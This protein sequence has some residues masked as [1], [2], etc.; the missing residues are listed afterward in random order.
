[1]FNSFVQ[2]A[3]IPISFLDMTAYKTL[4]GNVNSIA[5]SD[6][7]QM[8]SNVKPTALVY[9]DNHRTQAPGIKNL[10]KIEKNTNFLRSYFG[11]YFGRLSHNVTNVVGTRSH[12]SQNVRLAIL[13]E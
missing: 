2:L 4:N 12:L 8:K 1:M 5:F 6:A 7:G 13:Y 3:D 9:S 10:V 11:S